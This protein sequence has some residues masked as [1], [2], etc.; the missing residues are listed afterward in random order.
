MAPYQISKTGPVRQNL[1]ASINQS[2]MNYSARQDSDIVFSGSYDL[3][4]RG[5]ICV[6]TIDGGG[7]RGIIPARVLSYLEQS[8]QRQ[9]G[10][11]AARIADFFDVAAGTSI[12]G[13]LISMLFADDGKDR[14]LCTAADT[15]SFTTKKGSIVFK[16]NPLQQLFG[17]LRGMTR[18][19]Y[20]S[21]FFETELKQMFSREGTSLTL[22]NTLKPLLIPCYNLATASP[23]IFSRGDAMDSSAWDFRLWEV[24]RATSSVPSL[25]KPPLL[26]SVDGSNSCIAADGGLV[27]HNPAAAAITHVLHNKREFP[28]V[29]GLQD[30]LVLSIGTG[31]FDRKF[32]HAKVSNWGALQWISPVLRIIMDGSADMVDRTISMAF[33]EAR[34][35]YIRVQMSGLPDRALMEMDDPSQSNVDRLAK[36]ADDLLTEKGYIHLPFGSKRMLEQSNAERLD[37]LAGQLVQEQKARLLR[38]SPTV[39][40]RKACKLLKTRF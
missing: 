7:M 4:S 33:G 29:Q 16:L 32:E 15:Y 31:Q 20:S 14:P 6:L 34:H 8:L 25:F 18:P 24:C 28:H 40:L 39:I 5:K 1:D 22:R 10:N 30:L 23:F 2:A 36:Y 35:N 12:G 38:T 37:W 11:P 21:K 26:T 3:S 9:S 13:V 19:R 27:L 17:R